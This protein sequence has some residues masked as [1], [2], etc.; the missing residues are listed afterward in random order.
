[1]HDQ[2]SSLVSILAGGN[3]Q[4]LR[5]IGIVPILVLLAVALLSSSLVSYLYLLFCSNRG[6][7]SQIHR[8]FPLFGTCIVAIFVA[9]EFSAPLSL[10]LLGALSLVRFRTPIK[11][12]EEIGFIMLVVAVA[13]ACASFKLVFL[14]IILLV[15]LLALTVQ[16]RSAWWRRGPEGSGVIVVSMR[17]AEY[18]AHRAAI[19]EILEK[20]LSRGRLENLSR[21]DGQLVISYYL[22]NVSSHAIQALQTELTDRVPSPGLDVVL[23]RTSAP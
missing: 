5:Q 4:A 20:S 9:I 22:A 16:S 12:P 7:G 10:G 2:W 21:H 14:G 19:S 1:M 11:E 15:A 3:P 23:N 17:E 8:A 13:I 6:T 18:R